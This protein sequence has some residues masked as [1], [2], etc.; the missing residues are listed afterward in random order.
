MVVV[1]T[2]VVISLVTLPGWA[3][4]AVL[5][6]EVKPITWSVISSVGGCR[7][8]ALVL[9]AAVEKMTVSVILGS[10]SNIIGQLEEGR[11]LFSRILGDVVMEERRE[12]FVG[13]TVNR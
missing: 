11:F 9:F 3:G 6:L 1:T 10:A 5:G 13:R 7:V 8:G 4:V 12:A 2:V